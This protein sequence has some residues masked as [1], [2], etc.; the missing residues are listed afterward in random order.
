MK[1]L[2]LRGYPIYYIIY[3][4]VYIN[5]IYMYIYIY[6][7]IIYIYII[8]YIYIYTPYIYIYSLSLSLY[9]Y[10]YIYMGT[11]AGSHML[12]VNPPWPPQPSCEVPWPPGRGLGSLL[13]GVL[14]PSKAKILRN[15]QKNVKK[16][17][18]ISRECTFPRKKRKKT[19]TR[20]TVLV[21]TAGPAV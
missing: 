12:A 19:W 4:Y 5:I 11:G 10:I 2:N 16:R 7:Y 1:S 9:I 8:V 15:M 13:G 14:G 6:I 17:V 21:F 20:S 18:L 3:I